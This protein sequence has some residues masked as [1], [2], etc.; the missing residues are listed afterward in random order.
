MS[1][2][3]TNS[4]EH[5]ETKGGTNWW[6][7]TA[8]IEAKGSSNLEKIKYVEYQLH[9]SFKN[10]IK[11]VR[12]SSDGFALSMKGWGTFLL[13]ARVVFEDSSMKPIMLEHSL[14][15]S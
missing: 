9:S 11:R 2:V 14:Q 15:F 6:R 3:L 4:A 10:P 13:R 12:T 5:V 1:Y 8:F 7:W